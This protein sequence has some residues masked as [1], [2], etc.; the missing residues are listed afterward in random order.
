[1]PAP[2]FALEF[3]VRFFLLLCEL[4]LGV[5]GVDLLLADLPGRD[6]PVAPALLDGSVV[7]TLDLTLLFFPAAVSFCFSAAVALAVPTD[8]IDLLRGLPD[9][10]RLLIDLS[11]LCLGL[12]PPAHL[13]FPAAAA[14]VTAALITMARIAASLV[15]VLAAAALVAVAASAALAAA[16][17]VALLG[18]RAG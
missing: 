13:F 8:L 16:F 18:E 17:P 11:R 15:L 7:N 3:A 12:L 9:L 5:A 2:R 6:V 1:M 10:S 4:A 14:A